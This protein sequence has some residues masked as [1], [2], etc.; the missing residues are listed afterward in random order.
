MQINLLRNLVSTSVHRAEAVAATST[1]QFNI[2]SLQFFIRFYS[3]PPRL[4][5]LERDEVEPRWR[6]KS[7]ALFH[8]SSP[9]LSSS[10]P[11]LFISCSTA[12]ALYGGAQ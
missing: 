12:M 3:P 11:I 2:Y 4:L 5:R 10:T 7:F 6:P 9:A 8:L 1:Q